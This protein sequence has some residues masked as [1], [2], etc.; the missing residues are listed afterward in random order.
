MNNFLEFIRQPLFGEFNAGMSMFASIIGT[1]IFFVYL[2]AVALKYV[3][4]RYLL[5]E[6]T[7]GFQKGKCISLKLRHYRAC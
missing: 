1:A 2:I 7:H 5:K 3:L 4:P 6:R